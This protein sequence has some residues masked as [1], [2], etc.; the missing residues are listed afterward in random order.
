MSVLG[1]GGGDGLERLKGLRQLIVA[2]QRA[3]ERAFGIEVGRIE[4]DR[5]A[6]GF[7]GLLGFLDLLV[8]ATQSELGPGSLVVLGNGAEHVDRPMRVPLFAIQPG[9]VE[10]DLLG[11]RIDLLG[12][13]ELLFG[14]GAVVV[15]GVKLAEQESILDALGF[16]GD[17]L[18]VLGDRELQHL[19]GGAAG[20]TVAQRA[21]INPAKKFMGVEV[22]GVL[23]EQ[24][25]SGDDRVLDFSGLEIQLR[26]AAVQKLRG[27]IGVQ[28]QLV[29]LDR[30]GG[31]LASTV[32]GR[33][34]LVVVR[35][36]VMVVGGGAVG[37][38]R[39]GGRWV[40]RWRLGGGKAGTRRQKHH[41]GC[42]LAG[43]VCRAFV[44]FR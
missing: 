38:L 4:I 17:D 3:G 36:R 43:N 16:E 24:I 39:S 19:P 23:L 13:L 11:A 9:E 22:V 26:Q 1:I 37:S 27:G 30:A 25:L 5:A 32:R 33:H 44:A 20:L 35:E 28:R 7:D 40:R 34:L 21:Q 14:L 10:N 12:G 15:D 8:S 2:E 42:F 18:G 6:V 41:L 29:L 31:V